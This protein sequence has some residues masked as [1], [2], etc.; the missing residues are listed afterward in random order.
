MELPLLE[1]QKVEYWNVLA[2]RDSAPSPVLW[3]VRHMCILLY[4]S[5]IHIKES[6]T[7]SGGKCLISH[8]Y[9]LSSLLFC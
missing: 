3:A 7:A 5:I 1:S 6:L 4:L 9:A 2:R 8:I